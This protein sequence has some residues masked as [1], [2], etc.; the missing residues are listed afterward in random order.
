M[1]Q[2][3]TKS[4]LCIG[5]LFS[6]GLIFSCKVTKLIIRK[7]LVFMI[8]HLRNKRQKCLVKSISIIATWTHG[9]LDNM[10][11]KSTP[12]HKLRHVYDHSAHIR[13]I[14]EKSLKI[15][16]E[17]EYHTS[18]NQTRKTIIVLIQSIKQ[19]ICDELLVFVRAL[20]FKTTWNLT[21][22]LY[23]TAILVITF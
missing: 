3:V 9:Y 16:L 19:S 2:L 12:T 14:T 4:I 17:T 8:P 13:F 7:I 22:N 10:I 5:F 6:N 20:N 15:K 1:S 11:F 21:K 18:S 23:T